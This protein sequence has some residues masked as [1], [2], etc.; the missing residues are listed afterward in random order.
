MPGRRILIIGGTGEARLLAE[1][2]V[3]A[4]HRPV[5]SLAGATSRPAEHRGDVRVGGFGGADGLARYL[6]EENFHLL[7]DA[8][9]PFAARISANAHAAAEREGVTYLRLERP[10]WRPGEGERWTLVKDTA[11]AVERLPAGAVALVTIGRKEVVAFARRAD[12]TVV[13]RMIESP[14]VEVPARWRIILARPPFTLDEEHDLMRREGVSVVVS[15]NAGGPGRAKLDAARALGI[16]V[17]MIER[18]PKPGA[19]VV[20]SVDE[21]LAL[22]A[23]ASDAAGAHSS[24]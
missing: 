9:H 19:R 12:V 5:T 3:A 23:T 10:A 16:A 8:S 2:L 21:A 17:I 14:P 15:K 13:A 18:P 6:R 24:R 11:E 1:R 20:A 7:V 22:V 4:G